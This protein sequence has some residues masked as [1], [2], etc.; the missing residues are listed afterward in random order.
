MCTTHRYRTLLGA[1]LLALAFA[2]GVL[3]LVA[4]PPALA[5]TGTKA[6]VLNSSVTGGASSPEAT[7]AAANGFTVTVVDD[8]TWGAMTATQFAD[9]QLIVV[10]DPTCGFLPQVVSENATALSDAVMARA[11]G[12]TKVGNRILIGTDPNFHAASGGAKLVE[13]GIDFAG[14]VDGATNLFLTFSCGDQDYDGNGVQDGLDKL[15]PKVSSV[16][17]A[18]WSENPSAPCGGSVSLISNAAQFATLTSAH[19][20]G[21]FCSVHETFPTYPADWSPLAIATDT[22][23]A[24]TCGTD[25]DTG[26]RVCGEAYVLIA[27]S[28]IV[29]EAPDLALSPATATNNV[30]TQHTVTATVTNPDNSP[31]S[32]VTVS[33]VV[34][35]ANA[36]AIGTCVPA[37]CVSDASGLVTFTYTGTVA[38]DD[39]I[40]ASITI[41]GS[42]QSATAAK[43]WI[44]PTG[45]GPAGC[46]MSIPATVR[47]GCWR[48]GEPSGTAMLDSSGNAN[49]GT[50]LGGVTLGQPGALVGDPNTAALYDGVNDFGRVPDSNTL[51][52]GDSFTLEGWIKRSSTAKTHHLYNKGAN[53]LHLVVMNQGAGSQVF[54]RKTNVTTIAR[55]AGGVGAGTW[56]HIVATKNGTSSAKIYIDGVL[57]TVAVSPAVTIANTAF[58]LTFG[59]A[60]STP[61]VYDEFALY[62]TALTAAEVAAHYNAGIGGGA[63]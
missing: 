38:G 33:F 43:T 49:H 4:V 19:L 2:L 21:W 25:V 54:L 39:T 63:G 6:L 42:T 47:V 1:A 40:N 32:G 15:L 44:T 22:P 30:G 27:G 55:S 36:G 35:G 46:A 7:R 31:R 37:T 48:M 10:G 9:Y 12:N 14:V 45:P 24:P 5:E 8:A 20:Q 53:G 61:A 57:D 23:T 17:G 28:G 50:Y 3:L 26:A 59:V 16:A 34:T 58:P 29:A 52:V 62:D 60:D 11:G 51:D 41:D 56:H 13:T 18:T